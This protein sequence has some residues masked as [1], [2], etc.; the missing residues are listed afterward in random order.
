M[1][2]MECFGFL[3]YMH[4]QLAEPPKPTVVVCPPVVEWPSDLQKRAAQELGNLP[5]GAAL[6]DVVALAIRQRDV[7]RR[8]KAPKPKP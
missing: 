4:C 6:N 7:N 3:V 8:C 5:P 2:G 1:T